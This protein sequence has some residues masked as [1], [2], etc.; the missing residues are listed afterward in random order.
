MFLHFLLGPVSKDDSKTFRGKCQVKSFGTYN[1]TLLA[2]EKCQAL[3]TP[4]TLQA[5][6]LAKM[7]EER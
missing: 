3:A 7:V 4:Y 5:D 1:L 2:P 6:A